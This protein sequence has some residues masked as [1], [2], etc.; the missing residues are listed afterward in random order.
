[1]AIRGRTACA[2]IRQRASCWARFKIPETCANLSFVGKK[3]NWLF[4]CGSTSI[5]AV[6]VETQGALLR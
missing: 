1:M 3:R 5:Y 6:Y 4:I 2:T